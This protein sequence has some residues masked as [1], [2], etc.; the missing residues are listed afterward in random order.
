MSS[1]TYDIYEPYKSQS[2]VFRPGP[3]NPQPSSLPF[4]P[5]NIVQL[6]SGGPQMTVR[7]HGEGGAVVCHWFGA[8][9][10]LR[11]GSFASATIKKVK[12]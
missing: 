5:G 9:E 7:E 11:T 2:P 12:D 8:G 4:R 3:A 10:E 1:D 6:K